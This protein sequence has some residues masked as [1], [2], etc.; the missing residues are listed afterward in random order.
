MYGLEISPFY[1]DIIYI[2]FFYLLNY[3]DLLISTSVADD[4]QQSLFERCFLATGRGRR[5]SL[6]TVQCTNRVL[7][8]IYSI[9]EQK[10]KTWDTAVDWLNTLFPILT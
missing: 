2:G 3:E 1:M 6:P 10:L 9:K 7:L 8:Q 4:D 5:A